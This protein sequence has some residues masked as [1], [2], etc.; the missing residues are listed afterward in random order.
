MWKNII[1][2]IVSILFY[3]NSYSI[4]LITEGGTTIP[5]GKNDIKVKF[6]YFQNSGFYNDSANFSEFQIGESRNSYE[7]LFD[8]RYGSGK[9]SEIALKFPYIYKSHIKP[10]DN[11]FSGLGFG[12]I[13]LI[14]KNKV[15]ENKVS[16]GFMAISLGVKFPTGKSIYNVNKNVLPTGS[17]TWDIIGGIYLQEKREGFIIYGDASY[18]YRFGVIS[19]NF[20]GYGISEIKPSE[21][22]VKITP[23]GSFYLDLAVE[24]PLLNLVSVIMEL[25]WVFNYESKAEYTKSGSDALLDLISYGSPEITLQKSN[26]FRFTPGVKVYIGSSISLGIGVG[27]PISMVNNYGGL[28]YLV[29]MEGIF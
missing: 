12:D 15:I 2:L 3:G 14:G 6:N 8:L 20:A 16:Q 19:S 22:E 29:S 13:Y 7:I 21:T 26:I 18:A 27:I 1:I 10:I 17:G 25:N 5:E 23:G 11:K 9:D 4:P 28:T 24:Y